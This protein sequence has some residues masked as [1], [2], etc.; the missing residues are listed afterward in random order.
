MTEIFLGFSLGYFP[1]TFFWLVGG[2]V[3][4]FVQRRM[5]TNYWHHVGDGFNGDG[6]EALDAIF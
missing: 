2:W 5:L 4:H 6:F 1:I 3:F